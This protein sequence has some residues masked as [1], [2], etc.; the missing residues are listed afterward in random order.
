MYIMYEKYFLSAVLVILMVY[1]YYQD[2]HAQ[3][4]TPPKTEHMCCNGRSSC[5]RCPCHRRVYY[6]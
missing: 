1:L 6:Y 2:K 4:A 3:T 5:C